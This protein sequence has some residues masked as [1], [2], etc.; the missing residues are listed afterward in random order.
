[1]EEFRATPAAQL[2]LAQFNCNEVDIE[3]DPPSFIRHKVDEFYIYNNS[4]DV[5]NKECRTTAGYVDLALP[6]CPTLKVSDDDEENFEQPENEN[7]EERV[8]LPHT[9]SALVTSSSQ[10]V[11]ESEDSLLE[12]L[13]GPDMTHPPELTPQ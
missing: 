2:T 12:D 6:I 5:E 13:F 11:A 8:A 1:M 4:G 7:V 9:R 3:F 10:F